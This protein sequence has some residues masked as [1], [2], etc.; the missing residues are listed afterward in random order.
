MVLRFADI[1]GNSDVIQLLEETEGFSE[2]TDGRRFIFY[3]LLVLGFTG[4]VLAFVAC[5]NRHWKNKWYGFIY[6]AALPPVF[7][8]V[9]VMGGLSIG[10]SN[11]LPEIV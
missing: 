3:T 4:L 6:G 7:I 10:A 1:F 8:F 5:Q 9:I 2:F 11:T